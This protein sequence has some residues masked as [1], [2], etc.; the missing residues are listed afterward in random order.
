MVQ[1]SSPNEPWSWF[2]PAIFVGGCVV[3]V[4]LGV[5]W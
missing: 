3:A 2:L 1:K 4:V 5:L